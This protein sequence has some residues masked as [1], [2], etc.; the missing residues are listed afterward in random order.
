MTGETTHFIILERIL[1]KALHSGNANLYLEYK[2]MA[3]KKITDLSR[4]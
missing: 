3:V 4:I 2:L 1:A